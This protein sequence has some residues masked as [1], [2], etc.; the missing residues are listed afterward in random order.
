[1]QTCKFAEQLFP[2]ILLII[3]LYILHGRT[4]KAITTLLTLHAKASLLSAKSS[5]SPA[6][7]CYPLFVNKVTAFDRIVKGKYIAA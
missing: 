6:A 1:M 7:L 3:A 4:D 2:V 5:L